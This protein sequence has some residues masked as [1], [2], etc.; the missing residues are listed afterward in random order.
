MRFED[1]IEILLDRDCD[2]SASL[3]DHIDSVEMS[4]KTVK[5]HED[6]H[7]SI[8]KITNTM[9]DIDISTGNR[10]IIG[11]EQENDWMS[12]DSTAVDTRCMSSRFELDLADDNAIDMVRPLTGCFWMSLKVLENRNRLA[13]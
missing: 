10:K 11:L 1:R 3:L 2:M 8:K 13:W 12:V 9:V 5:C 4:E 7:F 6:R